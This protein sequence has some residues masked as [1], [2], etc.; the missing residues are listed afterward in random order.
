MNTSTIRKSL[1]LVLATCSA[2]ATADSVD[3][4]FSTMDT[5]K[6]G[7]VSA[8]EHAAGTKSFFALMDSNSDNKV[9]PGEMAAA[10][11]AITGEAASKTELSA[12]EKIR[13][14][15]ANGDGTLT[16]DEHA[17]ASEAMFAQMDADQD[18]FLSKAEMA[19]G[20]AAMMK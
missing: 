6:D 16:A 17:K 15:D 12:E 18:G 1:G 11:K 2:M 4:E 8:A 19:A 3:K 10:H 9:T 13:K 14:V 20:H 7:K 5:N